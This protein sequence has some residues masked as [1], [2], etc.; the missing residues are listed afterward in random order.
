MSAS[1]FR[2]PK[3]RPSHSSFLVP[4]QGE[5][6]SAVDPR[7]SRSHHRSVRALAPASVLLLVTGWILAQGLDRP[8]AAAV[9]A[10]LCLGAA[11]AD[12][13]SRRA[14]A[15]LPVAGLVAMMA[16]LAGTVA[17]LLL[18]PPGGAGSLVVQLLMV[19]VLA[20]AVPIFYALTFGGKDPEE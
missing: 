9:V 1:S 20:P 3:C 13:L 19:V 12:A 10:V 18:R 2:N 4:S 14:S 11:C 16:A 8:L 5:A 17:L 7:A 6:A 15:R